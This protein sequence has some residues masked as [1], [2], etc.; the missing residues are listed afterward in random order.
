MGRQQRM[1]PLYPTQILVGVDRSITRNS[2]RSDRTKVGFL[3]PIALSSAGVEPF[4]S[5]AFALYKYGRKGKKNR[6]DLTCDS[7]FELISTGSWER[8]RVMETFSQR[9]LR[10]LCR[11]SQRLF[12]V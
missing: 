10:G 6:T 3:T 11:S 1:L 9:T 5:R 4:R 2:G 7:V 12:S 8:A